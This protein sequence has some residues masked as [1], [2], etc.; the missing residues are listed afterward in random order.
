MCVHHVGAVSGVG[1]WHE[2]IGR[3][4]GGCG[5]DCGGGG[6]GCGGGVVGVE[7]GAQLVFVGFHCC[8]VLSFRERKRVCVSNL[9]KKKL[10]NFNFNCFLFYFCFGFLG[11]R[12]YMG[13]VGLS[14]W[15][16]LPFDLTF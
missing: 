15:I 11:V 1:I 13:G 4:R 12:F 16:G 9:H 2:A 8:V 14:R 6:C 3:R 10:F 7:V 5:R